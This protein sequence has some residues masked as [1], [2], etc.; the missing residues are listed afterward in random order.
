MIITG[1]HQ[2]DSYSGYMYLDHDERKRFGGCGCPKVTVKDYSA[3][4][5]WRLVTK[6]NKL[7]SQLP[8]EMIEMIAEYCIL[9]TSKRTCDII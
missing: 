2:F 4:Y 3:C 9:K 8:Q 6:T 5:N 1:A 7:W